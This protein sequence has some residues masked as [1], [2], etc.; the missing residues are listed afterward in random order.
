M[1]LLKCER[2]QKLQTNTL[3][4]G[5]H[6]GHVALKAVQKVKSITYQEQN[7]SCQSPVHFRFL[8]Y[9]PEGQV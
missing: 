1:T 5:F 4:R 7:Y 8:H 6:H 9:R 2:Q 3:S